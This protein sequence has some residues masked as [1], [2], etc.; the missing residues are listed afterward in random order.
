MTRV[1]ST[2]VISGFIR[3]RGWFY[4]AEVEVDFTNR[5]VNVIKELPCRNPTDCMN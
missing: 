4:R 5:K 1:A 2:V 3:H